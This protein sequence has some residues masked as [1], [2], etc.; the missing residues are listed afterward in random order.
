[1]HTE[2]ADRPSMEHGTHFP[3]A[4]G[5]AGGA[6]RGQHGGPQPGAW[7]GAFARSFPVAQ[8][9]SDQPT[10]N[11]QEN[12]AGQRLSRL[13]P[14]PAPSLHLGREEGGGAS[15][16]QGYQWS[17]MPAARYPFSLLFSLLLPTRKP[18]APRSPPPLFSSSSVLLHLSCS[19]LVTESPTGRYLCSRVAPRGE[20]V[21]CSLGG[22][23][24]VVLPMPPLLA[25]RPS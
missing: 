21:S 11:R 20:E 4:G 24:A 7:L 19:S 3:K 18:H 17:G 13:L 1:M 25:Q 22:G 9:S 5:G 14:L 16:R 6:R 2:R 15:C 23:D 8:A 10:R 12:N